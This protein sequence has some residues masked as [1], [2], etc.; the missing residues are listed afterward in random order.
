MAT[1]EDSGHTLADVL[2]AVQSNGTALA[3]LNERFDGLEGRFDGLNNRVDAL[4]G[5]IDGLN[6]RFDTL[7]G[8]IDGL[9]GRLDALE[10]RFDGLNGRFDALEGRLDSFERRVEANGSAVAAVDV[11]LNLALRA[12]GSKLD[13]LLASRRSP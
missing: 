1:G 10:G 2:R 9:N 7:E 5:R 3:A 6:K 4:E 12:I 8:R 13:Q 11:K